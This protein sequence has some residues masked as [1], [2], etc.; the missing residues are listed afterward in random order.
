M[1][2]TKNAIRKQHPNAHV[3]FLIGFGRGLDTVKPEV[4]KSWLTKKEELEGRLWYLENTN[5]FYHLLTFLGSKSVDHIFLASWL[6]FKIIINM[7]C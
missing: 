1:Q 7:L 3:F 4:L 6:H 5:L 2:K